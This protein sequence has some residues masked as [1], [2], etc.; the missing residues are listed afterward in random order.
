MAAAVL[1]GHGGLE[2]I[3]YRTDWPV[4]HPGPGQVLIEVLA[5]AINNTDINTRTGW[6]SKSVWT[7]TGEAAAASDGGADA[8]DATWSG[9]P[10]AFPRIQGA[11]VCG[12]IV[13][14]GDAVS[15]DRIGQ[16]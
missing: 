14:V 7:S 8:G 5:A 15:E 9:V 4:P 1:T 11:D 3:E 6:Y 10:L 2:K 12:R 16:R 13:E